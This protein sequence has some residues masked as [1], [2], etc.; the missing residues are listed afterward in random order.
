MNMPEATF[1]PATSIIP[2]PNNILLARNADGTTHL[3][4]P[5]LRALR[6][7]RRTLSTG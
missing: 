1:D 3:N 2:F 7:R 6:R 5:C 4:L